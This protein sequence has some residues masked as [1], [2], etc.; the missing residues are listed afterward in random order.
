MNVSLVPLPDASTLM[1]WTDPPDDPSA[2]RW[3]GTYSSTTTV[4][5]TSQC[6][7]PSLMG[8]VCR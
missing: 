3:F 5:L 2:M 1:T 8:I 6:M 4:S 7:G